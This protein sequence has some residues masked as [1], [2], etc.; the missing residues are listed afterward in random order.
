[1]VTSIYY[2]AYL[3]LIVL[4]YW[5]IPGRLG[6]T[7][8][9]SAAGM[10]FIG[11]HSVATLLF[12]LAATLLSYILGRLISLGKH[13]KAWLSSGI[14]LLLLAL[15]STKYLPMFKPLLD[16]LVAKLSSG[17]VL[18]LRDI[19]VPLGISYTVFRLISY[20]VDIHWKIVKPGTFIDFL[21][22]TTYF[23][24]FFAGPIER[25]EGMK[26]QL[27]AA[28][29]ISN[30]QLTFGYTRIILGVFKKYVLVNWL[31]AA[32]VSRSY[33][34]GVVAQ[35]MYV[36]AYALFI[37]L[38]FSAYSDIAIGSSALLGIKIRENFNSPYAATNIT[39]FWRRWHISLSDW[40]RDYLFFP[41]SGLSSKRMWQML[42]VPLIAM[43]LCGVWHGSGWKYL[44][45]GLFHGCLIALYQFKGK[46][47]AKQVFGKNVIG[48]L[49]AN[50]MFMG[51]IAV[52]WYFFY[53]PTTEHS[54]PLETGKINMLKLAFL[55]GCVVLSAWL[56]GGLLKLKL[57][58]FVS[59]IRFNPILMHSV[60]L[61]ITLVIGMFNS[62]NTFVYVDF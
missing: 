26:P 2:F 15:F 53:P 3:F 42:L 6:K 37:Y 10:A 5:A 4:C 45:W 23:P 50:L 12:L 57:P 35:A 21:C 44:A 61:V 22:Y 40:I 58:Q 16:A 60:L 41:L 55:A 31:F 29:T 32:M 49:I 30:E 54:L 52:S 38:D 9:L 62:D 39:D 27:E 34:G 43:G 46:S 28:A 51:V 47:I 59:A 24:I 25:F 7:L 1:M 33:S 8:L 56:K 17:K 14:A 36:L 20:L 11:Y 48:R 19:I 18:E 13:P